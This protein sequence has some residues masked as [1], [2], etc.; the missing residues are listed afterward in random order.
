MISM[1]FP[2]VAEVMANP[3]RPV[4]M[5][6]RLDFPTFERPM[7]AYSGRFPAGHLRTSVLLMIN[8]ALVISMASIKISVI[9]VT[10]VAL[11]CLSLRPHYESLW[12]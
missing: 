6:M 8:S 12:L 3:F 5:L 10:K 4:S 11:I 1:V 9:P 2:G 7:K